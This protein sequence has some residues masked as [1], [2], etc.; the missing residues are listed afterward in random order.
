MAGN[1]PIKQI[2]F[3][4]KTTKK[5]DYTMSIPVWAP[6]PNAPEWAS[7]SVSFPKGSKLLLPD[8]VEVVLDN[9]FANL[10]DN[11]PREAEEVESDVDLF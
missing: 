9:Y 1:R 6:H 11:Q 10:A 5:T 7:P 3:R 2:H 8:G 4:H